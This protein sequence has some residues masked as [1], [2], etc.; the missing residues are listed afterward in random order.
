MN[1]SAFIIIFLFIGLFFIECIPSAVA[2][3]DPLQIVEIPSS[4]NPVGSGARALGMGGAFIAIADDATAASWNPGGLIQLENPEI[5]VVGSYIDRT[6]SNSF[7]TSPESNGDQ[8]ISTANLNY[9]S[10]AYPFTI[11]N[12][13][14]IVAINYQH[15]FDFNREW[16][17]SFS[18]T[19][20]VVSQNGAASHNQD[21]Q[22]SALGLAYC[23][24]MTPGLSFGFTLNFWNDW[25]NGNEWETTGRFSGNGTRISTGQSF[26]FSVYNFDSYRF[27]GFNTNIGFLWNINGN[28]TLGAVFKSP[29]SAD[30]S[31]GVYRLDSFETTAPP[32]TS[33]EYEIPANT[34]EEKLDMPASYGIGISYRFSDSFTLDADFYHTRWND[35]N[36]RDSQGN[37]NSPISGKLKS[38]SNVDPTTQVR[39]GGEYL[40]INP[41]KQYVWA[42]RAGIFYD[43]APAEGTTDDYYG[44]S[45]GT[46]ITYKRIVF[47]IAYQFR[48]GNDIGSSILEGFGFSQDVKEHTVYSSIIFHF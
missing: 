31:H 16:N 19:S 6:E 22:L 24:Q 32:F 4:F 27:K 46:G 18:G 33:F 37:E 38:E 2:A 9:F 39:I 29:F 23:L 5:S 17:F 40:F 15:L 48:F 47:D 35:F 1:R 25:F 20:D 41:V 36:S 44:L 12:H 11:F 42:L 8:K 30:L 21:G 3:N 26:I 14:M 7:Y 45:L 13:N 34:Y 43:P 10:I 28:L